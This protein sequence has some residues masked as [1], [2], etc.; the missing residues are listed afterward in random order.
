MKLSRASSSHWPC[1]TAARR[2]PFLRHH[3]SI[4]ISPL[5]PK[6]LPLF[7]FSLPIVF[8][9]L[10]MNSN[11]PFSTWSFAEQAPACSS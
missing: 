7:F 5:S 9:A 8:M 3:P 1:L 10:F 4:N 6:P 2:L 11:W